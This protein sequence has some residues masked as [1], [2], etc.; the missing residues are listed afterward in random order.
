MSTIQPM[1]WELLQIWE[2]MT[3]KDANGYTKITVLPGNRLGLHL[4]LLRLLK[5]RKIWQKAKISRFLFGKGL[6]GSFQE[7]GQDGGWEHI[8]TSNLA[9]QALL[10]AGFKE[11]IED[12]VHWLLEKA[13]KNGAWGNKEEDINATALSLSTLGLYNRPERRKLHLLY[14]F[15]P[16]SIL[17][18]LFIY[19][20]FIYSL[21]LL[22]N[23]YHADK[24]K[25]KLDF[26]PDFTNK[27]IY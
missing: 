23:N 17:F 11:E 1:P 6:S 2:L 25:Y 16:H 9:I 7:K 26:C 18:C 4:L 22:Q 27:H 21:Q 8:S 20:S 12:S 5:N 24:Y 3:E 14:P 10:L 19:L 13:D 15:H